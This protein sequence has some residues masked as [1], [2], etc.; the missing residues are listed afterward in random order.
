M[1]PFQ[2]VSQYFV[3]G[4]DTALCQDYEEYKFVEC[5]LEETQ[6]IDIWYLHTVSYNHL[7]FLNTCL[8]LV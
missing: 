3:T 4:S 5:F 8:Q 7:S 2:P 1:S 6:I